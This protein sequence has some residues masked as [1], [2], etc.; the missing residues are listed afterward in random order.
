METNNLTL[1]HLKSITGLSR[2]FLAEVFESNPNTLSRWE[3]GDGIPTDKQYIWDEV[4][5]MFDEVTDV[6]DYLGLGWD[7]VMHIRQAAMKLGVSPITMR[8]LLARKQIQPINGGI[9]GDFI[10]LVDLATCRR[11]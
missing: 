9:L 7:D 6:L 5:H 2:N 8:S 10:T 11:P 1:T 3:A 4:T